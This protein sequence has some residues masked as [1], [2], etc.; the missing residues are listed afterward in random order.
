[1]L[2]VPLT[3]PECSGLETGY[4]RGLQRGVGTV[5]RGGLGGA[6]G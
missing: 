5:N 2:S 6:E 3:G 1:M 4:T